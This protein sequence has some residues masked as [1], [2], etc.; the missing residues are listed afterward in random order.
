MKTAITISLIVWIVS[1]VTGAICYAVSETMAETLIELGNSIDK[2]H[3]NKI[4]LWIGGLK[5]VSG[6]CALLMLLALIVSF[7]LIILL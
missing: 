2:G 4:I 7:I 1:L 6:I 5:L 3:Q